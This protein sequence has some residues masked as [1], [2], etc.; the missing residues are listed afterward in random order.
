MCNNDRLIQ[1]T[2]ARENAERRLTNA[3][4]RLQSLGFVFGEDVLLQYDQD[5]TISLEGLRAAIDEY[6]EAHRELTRF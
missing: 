2:I 4:I 6:L 5:K 3:Q 1:L